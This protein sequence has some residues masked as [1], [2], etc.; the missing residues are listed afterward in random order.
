MKNLTKKLFL[1]VATLALTVTCLSTTT[2]AWFTQN[3]VA[4]ANTVGAST[5]TAAANNIFI[6]ADDINYSTSASPTVNTPTLMCIAGTVGTNAITYTN[7]DGSTAANSSYLKATLYLQNTG[8]TAADIILKAD[9]IADAIKNTSTPTSF[10][11]ST[12]VDGKITLL[13]GETGAGAIA[14]GNAIQVDLLAAMRV[15]MNVYTETTYGLAKAQEATAIDSV[16]VFAADSAMAAA[17][18]SKTYS[19]GETQAN[20]AA[21]NYYNTIMGTAEE[22][23]ATQE[24]EALTALGAAAGKIC[25]LGAGK[26]VRIEFDFWIDGWD[27]E[28]FDAILTQSFS[29]DFIFT[30][31]ANAEAASSSTTGA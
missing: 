30:S 4:T 18:V 10:V 20:N 29:A 27:V 17:K 15:T 13:G 21:V 14:A 24:F 23:A 31:V 1:S 5:T 3:A 9:T 2:Y 6:S 12:S 7:L 25:S 22:C 8:T 19:D 11:P 28:A 16:R 26:V